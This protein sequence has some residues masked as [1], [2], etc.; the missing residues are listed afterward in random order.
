MLSAIQSLQNI[1]DPKMK[2]MLNAVIT[3]D[4]QSIDQIAGALDTDPKQVEFL[5]IAEC[6]NRWLKAQG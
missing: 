1:E 4:R 5:I 6:A 2:M 3:Q